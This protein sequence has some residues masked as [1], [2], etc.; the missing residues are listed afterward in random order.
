MK[1]AQ[2]NARKEGDSL[3]RRWLKRLLKI[4]AFALLGVM[5]L[6]IGV[7]TFTI[8]WRPFIGP[9]MRVLTDRKF[10]VTRARL[11]RGQYLVEG[12]LHCFQCHSQVDRD[13]PGAPAL[14]G[15]KGGG[16]I[17]TEEG[18]PWLVTPNITPDKET[19]AGN[20]TDD[21]MARA[22]REGI[23]HDGRALFPLMPY[24]S[25]SHLSDEDLASVVTY[26]RSIAPI[27]DQLPRTK[28]PFPL[29]LLLNTLPE[30]LTTAV[31]PPDSSTQIKRGEYLAHISDCAGCHTPRGRMSP[32]LAGYEF[33]GGNVFGQG[34]ATVAA[35][36]IT[37]DPSGISY[38]DEELFLQV[39]RT[40]HVKARK[41]NPVMPWVYMSTMTDEDLKSVFDYLRTLKP[42]R[43][44]VDNTEPPTKC[45]ICHQ[46]H[47]FGERN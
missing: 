16:R 41:L 12:S 9:R 30:P 24:R 20:W 22:I 19:G 6:L 42:V 23:G 7:I 5:I 1:K 14:A 40:G 37:P 44:V 43:H 8:G 33:A 39:M 25:Y 36:N 11:E 32:V 2:D 45:R 28:T 4:A 27:R 10:E 26:V 46:V 34:N 21:M 15:T 17:W 29:S 35:T 3:A 47:G 38:Y 18:F 31:P 13:A